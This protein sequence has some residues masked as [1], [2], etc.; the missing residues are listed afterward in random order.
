M[1]VSEGKGVCEDVRE[2]VCVSEGKG[3]CE[4]V[5]ERVCVS[6]YVCCQWMQVVTSRGC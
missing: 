1:C 4:D 3:V 5:R 2:R 6:V